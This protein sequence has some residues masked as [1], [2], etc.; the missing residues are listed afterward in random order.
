MINI[1]YVERLNASLRQ[2]LVC[3]PRRTRH[4][5]QEQATCS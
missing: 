5:V 2:R 4:L 1:A 3:L